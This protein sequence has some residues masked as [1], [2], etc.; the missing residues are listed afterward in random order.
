MTIG[1]VKRLYAPLLGKADLRGGRD[2]R[3]KRAV[4]LIWEAF[5][6]SAHPMVHDPKHPHHHPRVSWAGF[7]EKVE[8][9]DE[10]VLLTCRDKPACSPI[11][12]HGVCGR[13]WRERQAVIVDDVATL[14]PNYIA[15]DPCDRSELVVPLLGNDGSC[16]GVLDIDSHET[17]AFI[18]HDVEGM[19]RLMERFGLSATGAGSTEVLRL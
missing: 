19:K 7:Y 18:E 14:G 15:C 16:W 3:M 11:G 17:G 13:G 12:L 9:K 4:D 6:M 1:D 10:M 2:A 8:G 5:G